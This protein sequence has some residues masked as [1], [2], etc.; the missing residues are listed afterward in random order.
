[1]LYQPRSAEK[2]PAIQN[3]PPVS[4]AVC[5]APISVA[6][7]TVIHH[8]ATLG[9]RMVLKRIPPTMGLWSFP[10]TS[11]EDFGG[12]RLLDSIIIP[13]PSNRI[14]PALPI[15]VAK[16]SLSSNVFKPRAAR[17]RIPSSTRM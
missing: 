4:P 12:F 14:P 6:S 15:L 3:I 17:N 16:S 7:P 2:C 1:M 10:T 11:S 8:R 13:K 5:M 9:L